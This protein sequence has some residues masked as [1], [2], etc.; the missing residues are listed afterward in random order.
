MGQNGLKVDLSRQRDQP[1]PS[2]GKNDPRD[3]GRLILFDPAQS[4]G[5][6]EK[7]GGQRLIEG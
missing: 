1:F 4:V 5:D 6:Q 2:R 3:E 7:G